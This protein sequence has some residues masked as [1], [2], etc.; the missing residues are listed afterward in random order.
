VPAI[1]N[2]GG[3]NT[4]SFSKPNRT[5]TSGT[6]GCGIAKGVKTAQPLNP[7]G[8]E[9]GTFTTITKRASH[10]QFGAITVIFMQLESFYT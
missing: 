1:V 2:S 8:E 10:W 3:E 9:I 7:E 6:C 4:A 5:Q